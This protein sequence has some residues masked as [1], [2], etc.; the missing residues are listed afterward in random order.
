MLAVEFSVSKAGSC[1]AYD[2]VLGDC[3][4]NNEVDDAESEIVDDDDPFQLY[5]HRRLFYHR[6]KTIFLELTCLRTLGTLV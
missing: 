5:L 4:E 6:F 2:Q 1:E 3:G